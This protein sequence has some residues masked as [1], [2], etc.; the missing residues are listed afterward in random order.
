MSAPGICCNNIDNIFIVSDKNAFVDDNDIFNVFQ[1]YFL[2][3]NE[4]EFWLF[5]AR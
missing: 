4:L 3:I 5:V 1:S 2:F